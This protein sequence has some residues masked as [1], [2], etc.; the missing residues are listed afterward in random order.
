MSTFKFYISASMSTLYLNFRKSSPKWSIKIE[1]SLSICLAP[2][3][4]NLFANESHDRC[5]R[6]DSRFETSH[7]KDQYSGVCQY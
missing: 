3:S 6:K 1:T 4:A 7:R 5:N 2:L